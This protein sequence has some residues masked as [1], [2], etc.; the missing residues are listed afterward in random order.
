[1]P[2]TAVVAPLP[3]APWGVLL[4]VYFTV[5]GLPSGLTIA[6]LAHRSLFPATSAR[7][8]WR[9]SWACLILLGAAGILLTID[10][11]R[12]E[13]F[14]LMLSRFGNWDSPISLGAKIIAVKMFLLVVALYL[15]W[16]HRQKLTG[17]EFACST[18][19]PV[20]ALG[21][22]RVLDRTTS[23]SLVAASVALTVYPVAVLAR[24]W[25]SP[26]ATTSGSALIFLITSLIMGA[27]CVQLLQVWDPEPSARQLRTHRQA[28]LA[29][30][31]AYV[32][33][34]VFTIIS[35]PN[36]PAKQALESLAT[37]EWALVSLGL[38]IAAGIVV[39]AGLLACAPHHRGGRIAA[40]VAMLVGA[41]SVRYLIF[42]A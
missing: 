3:Q 36:G 39:P 19:G 33:V 42:A 10:L 14:F 34:V 40:A 26:L 13:R 18:Q 29:L 38:G 41:G 30:L 32:V 2:A 16:R 11:G 4:A 12:P 6:A 28:T 25:M 8:D 17:G 27:A 24:T 7:L 21:T 1:M 31:L 35:V 20:P 9:A 5:V 22:A 37:D 15:R 23:W